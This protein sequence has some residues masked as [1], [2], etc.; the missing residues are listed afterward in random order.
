MVDVTLKMCSFN[1]SQSKEFFQK[2]EVEILIKQM[3]NLQL[4]R[5]ANLGHEAFRSLTNAPF[6]TLF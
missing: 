1:F 3:A 4:A 6:A 5:T 2:C